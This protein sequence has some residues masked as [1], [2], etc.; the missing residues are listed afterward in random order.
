MRNT[1]NQWR[2]FCTDKMIFESVDPRTIEKIETTISR[3]GGKSFIVGGAVRD[4][5]NPDSPA[6]KDID[7]IITGLPLEKIARILTPL[8]K[9]DEVGKSFGIVKATIDGEEFDFALPQAAETK[10]GEKHTDFE[11]VTDHNLPVEDDLAR[12]DFTINAMAK[13]SD[14]NII[15][16]FGGQEDLQNKIIRAVGDPHERFSEDPLRI[17]RALQFA[18]RFGFTIE[19]ETAQAIR[20][21]KNLLHSISSERI[22]AEFAKA[23]TKGK[24]DTQTLVYWLKNLGIG[25]ELFGSDFQ[26]VAIN[27]PGGFD[28]KIIGN[29]IAFFLYGGNPEMVRPTNNMSKYLKV[30]Q[31]LVGGTNYIF[32]IVGRDTD[33][34]PLI[35]QAFD[36]IAASSGNQE[37][38]DTIDELKISMTLPMLPK[39]LAVTG[40]DLMQA[41]LSGREIG[42]A[43][44]DILIAIHDRTIDNEK[45]Q[46]LDFLDEHD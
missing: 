45:E 25:E 16:Q 38:A 33:T 7:F 40:N 4:E 2:K 20:D 27:M 6:S 21:L 12:R 34:L 8:G 9:V 42:K 46:I 41:G 32:K 24:A 37:L 31:A 36:Q 39:E 3:Y 35:L 14:G 28:E 29:F 19:P 15:D 18:T 10:T 11:V 13:D 26:P 30:A 17:L 44:Q 1:I 22:Y 5:L 23:W 43:M